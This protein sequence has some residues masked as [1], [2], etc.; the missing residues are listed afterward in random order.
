ME[1]T[2]ES[3]LDCKEI[4]PVHP[5]GNQSC[6]FIRRTDAEAET[7]ILWPP[8]A[9][10]WLTG[11][12]SD[13]G[14]DWKQEEKGMTEDEMSGWHQRLYQHE[15]EQAQGVADG[16]ESLFAAVQGVTKSR[17]RLTDWTELNWSSL[18]QWFSF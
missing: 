9:K 6:I 1:K 8:D 18:I 15:F 13:T 12:D 11:K 14:K 7:P 5:K 3:S 4:Q 16:Q 10:N 17:T 2:L